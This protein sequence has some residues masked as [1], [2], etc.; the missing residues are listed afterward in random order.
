MRAQT[1]IRRRPGNALMAL[2]LALLSVLALITLAP[3]AGAQPS[4]PSAP[5]ARGEYTL[6]GGQTS[7][8]NSNAIYVL[9]TANRELVA[10]RWNPNTSSLEGIGY[11]NLAQDVFA[12]PDR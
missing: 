2:N 1:T 10:L 5:R 11:R 12:E 9:D 8:G 6:V 7:S 3:R 4:D